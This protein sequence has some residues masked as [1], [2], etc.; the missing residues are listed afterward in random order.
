MMK[1][2]FSL[3]YRDEISLA[4]VL[5]LMPGTMVEAQDGTCGMVI[6]TKT[7]FTAKGSQD[8]TALLLFH[9][10]YPAI[11]EDESGYVRFKVMK[12]VSLSFRTIK[13]DD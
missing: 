2:Y 13:E 8:K 9:P 7:T 4:D 5:K 6:V 10:A 11:C 3:D 12:P 1:Y